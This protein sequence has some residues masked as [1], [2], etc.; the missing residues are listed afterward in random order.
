MR[1]TLPLEEKLIR[2]NAIL[3]LTEAKLRIVQTSIGTEAYEIVEQMID[4][5]I[6]EIK[7]K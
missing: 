7:T 1:D 3:A 5:L 4:E 6:E 2:K